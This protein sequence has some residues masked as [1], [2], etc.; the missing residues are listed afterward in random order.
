MTGMSQSEWLELG[1]RSGWCGP[2]VCVIH[3][4]VPSTLEEDEDEFGEP[5]IPMVRLYADAVERAA[6]EE[7][8]APS[9]W[10]RPLAG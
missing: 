5:C 7:N 4:G 10:R 9:L 2:A 3:D 1:L 6:V 8:H